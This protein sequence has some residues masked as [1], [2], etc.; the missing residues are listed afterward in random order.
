[1]PKEQ[2]APAKEGAGVKEPRATPK[3][4]TP[5]VWTSTKITRQPA[6]V[7][8]L[9]LCAL[10]LIALVISGQQLCGCPYVLCWPA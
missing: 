7:Y 3:R 1:M 8:G 5:T 9:G 4:A 6:G 2:Q 10:L